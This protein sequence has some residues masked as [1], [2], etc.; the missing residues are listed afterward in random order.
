MLVRLRT[1]WHGWTPAAV[2]QCAPSPGLTAHAC[3]TCITSHLLAGLTCWRGCAPHGMAG[4]PQPCTCQPT[5][6]HLQPYCAWLWPSLSSFTLH[7]NKLVRVLNCLHPRQSSCASAAGA[8]AVG[9]FA[10]SLPERAGLWWTPTLTVSLSPAK[11]Y[12][13]CLYKFTCN[14]HSVY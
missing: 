3:W 12:M 8:L 7:L 9:A 1:A 14:A 13:P 4:W 5:P 2:P 6:P 10:T 11:P